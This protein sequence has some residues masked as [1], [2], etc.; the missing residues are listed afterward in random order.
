MDDTPADTRDGG[1]DDPVLDVRRLSVA[2]GSDEV[3]DRLD[4]AVGRGER[5]AVV[6][7]G[8]TGKTTLALALADALPEPARRSGTVTYRPAGGDPVSVFDLAD[9]ERE[10]LRREGVAVV[11]GDGGFEPTSPLRGQFRP[12]LRASGT[13]EERAEA[14]VASLG[15]DP[16]RVLDARPRELNAAALELAELARA[17]LADP[18]VL[19]VDDRPAA[20]AHLARGDRLDGFGSTVGCDRDGGVDRDAPDAPTVL[21]LGSELPALSAV[22]DRLAVLHDGHVVE[23][24]ATER[25]LDDP[26]HPY[27]RRLVEYYGGSP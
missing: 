25:V 11:A 3:L 7:E 20:L 8:A 17:A 9:D 12:A 26:S 18:A 22:A 15:L 14:L 16:D 27:T 4:L 13:D 19:V 23:I 24:G 6:G 1:P 10:R 21:A 5:L 2:F